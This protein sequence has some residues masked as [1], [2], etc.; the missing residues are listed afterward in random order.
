M[1]AIFEC[2]LFKDNMDNLPTAQ[3]AA[4]TLQ[5]YANN[6]R[7][8]LE[9]AKVLV[10]TSMV[11]AHFKKPEEVVAAV[12]YGQELGFSP[13]QALQAVIVI[14]G[15]PSL[16]TN[17]IKA[18]ILQSGGHLET[19]EWTDKK[20]KLRGVR[21]KWKEEVEYTIEDATLAGLAAKD[22]WKKMPKAMLYARCVSILGRNMWAD[23]LKGFFGREELEDLPVTENTEPIV[24]PREEVVAAKIEKEFWYYVPNATSAQIAFFEKN[25]AVEYK[26]YEVTTDG[27][28]K[29]LRGFWLS[30]VSLGRKLDQYLSPRPEG[31]LEVG[32]GE[33]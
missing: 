10:S 13:M 27:E 16:E 33:A 28:E 15:K 29:E 31:P 23:L 7:N 18:L 1:W 5:S 25:N 19:V 32:I 30:Y 14:Q 6:L 9:F 3:S 21:G 20:C 22:N 2:K 12:L 8:S 17:A 4:P 24:L 11:P 26:T